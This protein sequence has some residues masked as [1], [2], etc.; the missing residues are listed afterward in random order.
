[1]TFGG[2]GR[3]LHHLLERSSHYQRIGGFPQYM[4]LERG[5][6]KVMGPDAGKF[7]QG[8]CSNDVHALD[9][10]QGQLSALLN[11]RG[12]LLFDLFLYRLGQ[13]EYWVEC[14][15]PYAE[16]VHVHF[17]T[18]RLKS[19]VQFEDI[20]NSFQVYGTTREPRDVLATR[21]VIALKDSRCNWPLHRVL[22]AA[23]EELSWTG[24]EGTRQDYR[25]LRCVYGVAEGFREMK[26]NEGV[27]HECNLDLMGGVHFHKGCFIG[28]ELVN[29]IHAKGLVRK[30]IL[31]V[32][33]LTVPEFEEAG[34]ADSRWDLNPE[35]ALKAHL[36]RDDVAYG[37]R[38][39]GTAEERAK[40]GTPYDVNMQI[41]PGQL[42]RIE[43]NIALAKCRLDVLLKTSYDRL[44]FYDD[45]DTHAFYVGVPYVPPWWP[46]TPLDKLE[47]AILPGAKATLPAESTAA[48]E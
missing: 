28:Q 48:E 43:G 15:R 38:L 30:R 16:D 9:V 41:K 29:R 27:P 2:R 35:H 37:M 11:H 17:L 4:H 33:L 32:K 45:V 1:M 22:V 7:L 10:G 26:W 31:P 25:T 46:S 18:Y 6:V 20:T 40:Y 21:P 34:Y 14:Q 3:L 13:Q 24:R 8:L 47:P 19:D 39:R 44:M 42:L 36:H 5:L 23:K 12:R